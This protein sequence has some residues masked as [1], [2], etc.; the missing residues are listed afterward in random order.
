MEGNQRGSQR[1][2]GQTHRRRPHPGG[3]KSRETPGAV[4]AEI[5]VCQGQ[6]RAGIQGFHRPLQGEVTCF[7][8][9]LPGIKEVHM[10]Q[11]CGCE[12]CKTCGMAIKNGVCVG[13]S[14]PSEKCTCKKK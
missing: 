1:E 13:C 12:P 3:R 11:T 9:L 2:V 7:R 14:Q 6:G 10:C 4:A 8:L 5:R